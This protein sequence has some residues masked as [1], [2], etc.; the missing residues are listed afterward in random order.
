MRI[1]HWMFE[2]RLGRLTTRVWRRTRIAAGG[3]VVVPEAPAEVVGAISPRPLLV[4]HGAADHYFPMSHVEALAAAAPT[5]KVWI[6]P[7]M[8]HAEAATTADLVGRIA[9]WV[10]DASGVRTPVCDDDG[11]E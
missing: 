9:A 4:V 2:K 10:L 5:A 11:R 8:G 7:A 3:W 6:E 1:V